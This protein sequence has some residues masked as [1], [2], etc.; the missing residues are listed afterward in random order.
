MHRFA[1]NVSVPNGFK[2]CLM[3]SA[4]ALGA[5]LIYMLQTY[6]LMFP[7]II[8]AGLLVIVY[9]IYANFNWRKDS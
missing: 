6:W 8:I 3:I 7:F 9:S 2:V 5:A 1:P 4:M